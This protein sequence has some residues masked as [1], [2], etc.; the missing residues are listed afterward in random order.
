MNSDL[1]GDWPIVSLCLAPGKGT[2]RRLLLTRLARG[3]PPVTASVQLLPDDTE[4]LEQW[5]GIMEENRDTL[6][7][8]SAEEAAGWGGKEKARWWERRVAV[9]EM[10]GDLLCRLEERWLAVHGLVAVLLGEVVGEELSVELERA[11]EFAKDRVCAARR[12]CAGVRGKGKPRAKVAMRH[13]GLV[14]AAGGIAASASEADG[15][16]SDGMSELIRV[17]V[18][19]GEVMDEE[20]WLAVVRLAL[21]DGGDEGAAAEISRQIFEK[22]TAVF[23][24][25]GGQG[26]WHHDRHSP[27]TTPAKVDKSS[28]LDIERGRSAGGPVR[29]MGVQHAACATVAL[30]A[31][32]LGLD[33]AALSKMK[34]ADL[35]RELSTREISTTG[36]KLKSDLLARLTEAVRREAEEKP[37]NG[38]LGGDGS[39][40]GGPTGADGGA[41]SSGPP[42]PDRIGVAIATGGTRDWSSP[43][44]VQ[45]AAAGTSDNADVAASSGVDDSGGGGTK[46]HPVVLVLD[47][48]LQAIPWE[49]LPCLRGRAVT[50]VPAVPFVFSALATRWE[51]GVSKTA[52]S[53]RGGGGSSSTTSVTEAPSAREPE[54]TWLPAQDGV[55]L[56]RGFYV[57]DP[58]A[59][60][61]H[62]RKQL[63][64]VF[65]G[66]GRRRG[67][68]G[69][70]GKAP[71]EEAMLRALA[72][73]DIFAYCGHGAG[74]VIVG[75]D[76]VAGLKRCAVA[77]LMGCSSGRM[78]GY[79]DFEPSGMVSSY[80][81]GGSPAVV[82]NLWDVTDRD[83]DRYSVALLEAFMGGGG[84]GTT[85]ALTLAHAVAEARSECKMPFIIGHA[86]VCYGIPVTVAASSPT[87]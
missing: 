18:R 64:P 54:Q 45:R 41:A 76:A 10:V 81:V 21:S 28:S 8:H 74:E 65:E 47:E 68:A 36:L 72:E 19:G 29:G 85:R 16:L 31:T 1:R 66:L 6:R 43:P 49:G 13:R 34:V 26:G 7:G 61:P 39:I 67:W 44:T 58:E 48:E 87:P 32:S 63:W 46:R 84:E 17:C 38:H 80:L 75:R 78:K 35:R 12:A 24:P 15:G 25:G 56:S 9:D 51:G 11:F 53:A 4:L 60:L 14:R 62:T 23:T 33:K 50:R 52:T 82:A 77:V 59:N 22:V 37:D 40:V 83:I 69:V 20:A 86:P 2:S 42:T 5:R 3:R 71:S 70:K 27:V 73:V 55:R 30:T 57:L 79:G